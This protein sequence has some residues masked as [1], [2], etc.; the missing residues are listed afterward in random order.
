MSDRANPRDRDPTTDRD[1][2]VTR[3]HAADIDPSFPIVRLTMPLVD[4]T[5]WRRF[6]VHAVA[7]KTTA[8]GI[9]AV[10]WR[11]RPHPGGL[12]CFDSATDLEDGRILVARHVVAVDILNPERMI[13]ALIAALEIVGKSNRC[14]SLHVSLT[15]PLMIDHATHSLGSQSMI[16]QICRISLPP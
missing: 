10:R 11:G 7:A 13:R 14:A 5:A 12:A 4:L 6:A 2:I 1:L 16:T 8:R 3:L 9:L 15:Q